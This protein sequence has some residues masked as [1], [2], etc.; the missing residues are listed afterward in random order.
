MPKPKALLIAAD[1]VFRDSL[2]EQLA[3]E[4]D[5]EIVIANSAQ[6]ARD[7]M[8]DSVFVFAVIDQALSSEDRPQDDGAALARDLRDGGFSA[9]ILLLAEPSDDNEDDEWERLAKPF[10]FTALMQKLGTLLAHP[11]GDAPLQIGPYDFHPSAKLLVEGE[12]RIRLTEK[13]TDILKY[14]KGAAGIVPRQTLLGEVWG[15]GPQVA[16]H[17]LETHIYRLRKKIEQDPGEARILLTEEG[18]YRLCA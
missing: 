8:G 2:A 12:R 17:T 14:L 6:G 9:P 4:G 7:A 1:G 18:G 5:T 13:E 10:R 15:Y 3:R 11:A 16:T